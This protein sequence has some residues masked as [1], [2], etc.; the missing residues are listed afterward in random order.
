MKMFLAAAL[1]AFAA[2]PALAQ[3]A[4]VPDWPA[5]EVRGGDFGPAN[6]STAQ[7]RLRRG[8]RCALSERYTGRFTYEVS[9]PPRNGVLT[10]S[11]GD[12]VY[13]PNAGFTGADVFVVRIRQASGGGRTWFT[14]VNVEVR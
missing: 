1:V 8:A 6:A 7:M 10:A 14:T 12:A 11:G 9:T 13:Q 2:V 5:C 3:T 4:S